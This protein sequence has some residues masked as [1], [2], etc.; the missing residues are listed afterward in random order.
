[1]LLI[2]QKLLANN[3]LLKLREIIF[4]PL[5]PSDIKEIQGDSILS[6]S[7]TLSWVQFGVYITAVACFFK[8]ISMLLY[9][10]VLVL[11]SFIKLKKKKKE[12]TEEETKKKE[13]KREQS[14]CLCAFCSSSQQLYIQF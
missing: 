6:F 4:V 3:R 7:L 14:F 10:I 2:K 5:I 1:M 13:D 8:D 11:K 12:R 9:A